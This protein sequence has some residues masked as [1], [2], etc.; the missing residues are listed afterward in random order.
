DPEVDVPA[1][2]VTHAF[3]GVVVEHA[4]RIVCGVGERRGRII[5]LVVRGGGIRAPAPVPGGQFNV[6]PVQRD[7]LVG[8]DVPIAALG[9]LAE[10][11]WLD[12]RAT[13][14]HQGGAPGRGKTLG[15]L[16]RKE[17]VAVADHGNRYGGGDLGDGVPVGGLPV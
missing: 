15:G 6:A 3:A 8:R 2:E 11:P 14:R 7:P 9:N 13:R 5:S 4:R 16:V 17:Q 10:E 12:E 1:Q